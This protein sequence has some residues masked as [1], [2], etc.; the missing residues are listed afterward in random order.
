[1]ELG[2]KATSDLE[3]MV[4]LNW[5]YPILMTKES[6]IYTIVLQG[7]HTLG[8]LHNSKERR[9]HKMFPTTPLGSADWN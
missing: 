6:R 7:T 3:M 2:P 8:P 1:M 9:I 4:L 5:N